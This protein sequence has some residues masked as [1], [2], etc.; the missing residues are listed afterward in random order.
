MKIRKN[1]K[2][3]NPEKKHFGEKM[4]DK[5]VWSIVSIVVKLFAICFVLMLFGDKLYCVFEF[6]TDIIKPHHFDGEVW[7]AGMITIGAAIIA[8]IPGIICGFMAYKQTIRLHELEDRYHLPDFYL[9]EFVLRV[10]DIED[11]ENFQPR[12]FQNRK[13]IKRLKAAGWP[14]DLGME[15]SFFTN[16][17]SPIKKMNMKKLR[18]RY[19]KT[20]KEFSYSGSELKDCKEKALLGEGI[21][22]NLARECRDNSILYKYFDRA[23]DFYESGQQSEIALDGFTQN[24]MPDEKRRYMFIAC[25]LSYDCE[26]RKDQEVVFC[27]Y[28]DLRCEQSIASGESEYRTSNGIFSKI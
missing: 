5:P 18:V 19:G 25:L 23:N 13:D 22:A 20:F 21:F 9:Q 1:A 27:T 4:A 11:T 17:N 15:I 16:N 8:A 28:I 6:F 26:Y 14:F 24:M 3:E 2:N 12:D 7:Y 10:R